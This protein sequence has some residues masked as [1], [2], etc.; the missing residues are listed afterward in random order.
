MKILAYRFSAFG[1]VVMAAGILR[2]IQ[3]QNPHSEVLFLS[4][5]QYRI[6][7]EGIE[8]VRFIG[9][10]LDEYKGVPGLFRLFRYLTETYHPDAVADLHDVLRTK[11]L[12]KLFKRKGIP[13]AIIN[14]GKKDKEELTDVKNL[15]KKPLKRTVERYADVF[16]DLGL[17]VSLSHRLPD[18]GSTG[19]G[20]GF[21]PFAQHEGKMLS[22]EK[23]E[24]LLRLLSR[25]EKVYLFGGGAYETG[26]L[27]SWAQKY[28][29]TYCVAGAHTLEEEL[30]FIAGLR[31]MVSMDSANMHLASFTGTRCV[32]V[33]CATHPY[34]G[35]LGYGQSQEDVVEQEDLTCRPC[36]VFGNKKCFRGDYAC[37][38]ELNLSRVLQ[39]VFL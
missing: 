1:D 26:I 35:F 4:R 13:V 8:N 33:W 20:I 9:I 11:L 32:S 10:N 24:E 19:E 30:N 25:K 28:P 22:M 34:A 27:Q 21:A 29:N 2:E 23:S 36:S 12:S 3:A 37:K 38:T 31:V 18:K 17:K 5:E 7:F 39:R 15:H 6:F 16:R 14:K